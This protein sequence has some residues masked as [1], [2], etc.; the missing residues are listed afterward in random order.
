MYLYVF[1]AYITT[2]PFEP[3]AQILLF[4]H[5]VIHKTFG[6][7]QMEASELLNSI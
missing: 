3:N 2:A 4:G 7:I 1:A 6:E 5:V